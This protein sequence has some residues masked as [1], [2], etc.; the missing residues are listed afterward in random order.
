MSCCAENIEELKKKLE[1]K[2]QISR[3]LKET[4]QNLLVV[5]LQKDLIIRQLKEKIQ[6]NKFTEFK[7]LL[8]IE[9][10]QKLNTIGNSQSDDSTFIR[11]ALLDLYREEP[12]VLKKKTLT[13]NSRDGDKTIISPEKIK[14]LEKLFNE[15]FLYIQATE[16]RKNNLR[17][18]IRNTIDAESRKK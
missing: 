17:K 12:T 5:N 8:S 13:G 11:V 15:R 6:T 3:D 14:I 2:R 16:E 18:L 4:Y 1:E 7:S 9:G 10:I